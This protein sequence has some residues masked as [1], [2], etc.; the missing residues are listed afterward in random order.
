ME[1]NNKNITNIIKKVARD[2]NIK[3]KMFNKQLENLIASPTQVKSFIFK[4]SCSLLQ[5]LIVQSKLPILERNSYQTSLGESFIKRGEKGF[6]IFSN[7]SDII[8]EIR[9]LIKMGT[10]SDIYIGHTEK[11]IIRRFEYHIDDAIN[12]YALE[13]DFPSRMIEKAIL[14]AIREEINND[15]G[16]FIE[17]Y[18][19]KPIHIRLGVK[20][21]LADILSTK[22]FEISILEKHY[23]KEKLSDREK[24]YKENYPNSNGTVFPYGLNMHS[25]IE[26]GGKYIALPLYDIA[27]MISLGFRVPEISKLI[28]KFYHIKE[29]TEDNVYARI[30]Q[31]FKSV[32]HAE[33]ILLK[34]VVQLILQ[35][36]PN[37]SGDEIG[38]IIHREGGRQFFAS[39]GCPFKRWFGDISL[40][41]LKKAVIIDGFNW[42][43]VNDFIEEIRK[44]NYIRGF[45]KSQWIE[46]FIRG[47][48]NEDL[49]KI[50]SYKYKDS[51]RKHF[52]DL[53]ESKKAFNVPNRKSAVKKYR[54][55]KT[56]V[57]IKNSK[58]PSF[59]T[60]EYLYTKVFGFQ[61][62]KE[63]DAKYRD[64]NNGSFFFERALKS[65][66]QKLF[67][68]MS[69]KEIIEK[70]KS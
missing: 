36:F 66:F 31:F 21:K 65:Y 67:N 57:I 52:F 26:S 6:E 30:T 38:K 56:I 46:L 59:S 60:F 51:F 58:C 13:W 45:H 43:D 50:A 7:Y 15:L 5:R 54:K 69:L 41:E 10:N 11:D 24:W 29:A 33:D 39:R 27:F 28:K 35:R 44:G 17:D 47:I 16:V 9:S 25:Y 1:E 37:L 40:R 48:S 19:S 23:T 20:K 70:Y 4:S 3:L 8:Y 53:E 2:K 64:Y 22:Y 42:N 12:G 14:I 62:R 63:Y 32:E 55:L 34:P 68:G 49:S 61:S 18:Q